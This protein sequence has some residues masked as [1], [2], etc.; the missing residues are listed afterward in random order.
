MVEVKKLSA[1]YGDVTILKELSF[2]AASGSVTVLLGPN[3]CGK[4]TLLKSL[5]GI[6]PVQGGDIVVDG[7]SVC[8]LEPRFLAQK[9]AYLPQNR[10]IPQITVS[11]MVLHGRFPYLN[12][13]RRYRA[14]DY[15]AANQAMDQMGILD[16]KDCSLQKLS[17]G[18]RQK[19]YIAMALAQDTP[20]ILLD[21]PTTF[22]DAAHQLQMMK[23]AKDLSRAGK[24][25]ILVSHDL[26]MAL[27]NADQVI[28]M[29]QGR[30]VV[31]G[32]A[33]D[34]FE[35]GCLDHVFGISVRRIQTDHGWHYYYI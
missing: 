8:N 31:S 29:E 32:T 25:V 23:Q 24:S 9:I 19:V 34:V 22:L 30:N 20:V 4:S 27:Q 28:V 2:S 35:T 1:G 6:L 11:R 16:L 33:E 17:G 18:Q 13:P 14:E 10:P 12:Y 5:C 7:Q 3:G 15:A 26:T 21:E